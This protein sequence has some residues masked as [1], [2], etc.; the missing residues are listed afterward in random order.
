[1]LTGQESGIMYQAIDLYCER[2]G[3]GFWAEPANALSNIAFIL[4]GLWALR[5]GR[6]M[7]RQDIPLQVLIILSFVIGIGSFLFHTFANMWSSFADVIP[8]WTFVGVYVALAIVRFAKATSSQLVRILLVSVAVTGAI[9]WVIASGSASDT[10]ASPDRFNGSLQYT[11]AVIALVVFAVL[12]GWKKDPVAPWII[13]A[14]VTFFISLVFRTVDP[15]VCG[16]F[17]VGTHFMWHGLN[18]LM[19]AL[20]LQ[21]MIHHINLTRHEH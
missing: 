1:M 10:G 20:L 12:L 16:M 21:A 11:P 15:S 8:I 4:A 6:S 19:I 14:A 3:P 7:I 9:V 2:F 13:G 5:S 18:G 17:P